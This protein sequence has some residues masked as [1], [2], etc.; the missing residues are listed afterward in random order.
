LGAWGNQ[1]PKGAS[2]PGPPM[3]VRI[4]TRPSKGEG[5]P[6]MARKALVAC[7]PLL[8]PTFTHFHSWAQTGNTPDDSGKGVSIMETRPCSC[9][10]DGRGIITDLC[11]AHYQVYM[12]QVER[13]M[14]CSNG[15]CG[16]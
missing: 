13:R 10:F 16:D 12:A 14:N 7:A 11:D 8:L 6:R 1:R 4:P 2:S 15:S 5:D 9:S 3:V